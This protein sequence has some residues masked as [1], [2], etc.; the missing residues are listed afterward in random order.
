MAFTSIYKGTQY[1]HIGIPTSDSCPMFN[2]YWL[3][4]FAWKK[5]YSNAVLST[6]VGSP[7]FRV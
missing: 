1:S 2:Y 4:D 6:G 5:K 3:L 7:P